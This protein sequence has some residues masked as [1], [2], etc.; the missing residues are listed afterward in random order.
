MKYGQDYVLFDSAFCD[1]EPSVDMQE[2]LDNAVDY[3]DYFF[4][5]GDYKYVLCLG[6][7]HKCYG[8]GRER[9]IYTR[10]SFKEIV[11]DLT[12][13]STDVYIFVPAQEGTLCLQ[14]G[15]NNGTDTYRFRLLTK[16]GYAAIEG[17][18]MD[19][20]GRDVTFDGYSEYEMC[21]CIWDNEKYSTAIV[22]AG[23]KTNRCTV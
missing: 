17:H 7:T 13:T 14:C 23:L 22:P 1:N 11:K 18:A 21:K 15:D 19:Y 3:V 10:I 20:D 8:D 12:R 6:E 9:Q 4:P 2:V 16:V 5:N